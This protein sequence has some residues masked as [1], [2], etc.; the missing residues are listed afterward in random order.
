[1]PER[2]ALVTGA[3]GEMGHA[4]LSALAARGDRIVAVD[5]AALPS[6][7]AALC[8]E[9]HT[10]NIL[11]HA[12][13]ENLFRRH[14]P[15]AVFHL[16]A[17]LSSKAEREPEQAH[18]VNVEATLDLFRL[19]RSTA[20]RR[21]APVRFLFPSSIAVYGLP[22]A[23]VK[24]GVP[25]LGEDDFTRP[26]SMYGCNKL[27]CEMVGAYWTRRAERDG[28]PGLDFRAIRFPGLIS[29]ETLP[30]GGTSDY[31][32]EMIHAAAQGKGYSCFVSEDTR[33]P[34]MTMPDAVEALLRLESA[35]PSRLS[36]R[37]YNIRAFS[38]SA[39][40]FLQAVKRHFPSVSVRFEPVPFRQAI[41]DTWPADVDDRVARE[42]WGHRPSHDLDAAV[43]SYLV[44]ALQRRYAAR[45]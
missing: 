37:T 10:G 29:A 26:S 15:D 25:P 5:L 9:A 3:M 31:L 45:V 42:D 43:A 4:L 28:A 19:A 27:Y 16:A 41:V 33:L 34:F 32:P 7:L 21:N 35:D 39:G 2:T 18:R 14:T 11:D 6:D 1:M 38:P 36:R 44:P 30:S 17:F 12:L 22:G 20:E 23:A 13:M 24:N 8:V 40:E